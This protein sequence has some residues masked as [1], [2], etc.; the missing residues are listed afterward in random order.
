MAP[1]MSEVEAVD[2]I[3]SKVAVE[4][5]RR[6]VE[7][8]PEPGPTSAKLTWQIG[9]FA[10]AVPKVIVQVLDALL[11]NVTRP[12]PF[13]PTTLGE[14]AHTETESTVPVETMGALK[15]WTAVQLFAVEVEILENG[16]HVVPPTA[17]IVV[18]ACPPLQADAPPYAVTAP[19]AAA[20]CKALVTPV[21]LR[22]TLV[23]LAGNAK[24]PLPTLEP[25]VAAEMLL[26]PT[27][28]LK[29]PAEIVTAPAA[30]T[31]SL[32]TVNNVPPG[33]TTWRA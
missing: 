9:A 13:A 20:R 11:P 21:T 12:M 4:L 18:T 6:L 7:V 3:W 1:L 30:T 10:K 28:P 23:T 17:E 27:V 22:F 16:A 33:P 15:V 25:N 24:F 29:V 8:V 5:A 19:F 31:P 32:R 2:N 14:V 26:A